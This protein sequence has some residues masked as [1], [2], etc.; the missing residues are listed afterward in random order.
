MNKIFLSLIYFS[1]VSLVVGIFTSITFSSL[2]HI[3][4]LIAYVYLFYVYFTS[5]SSSTSTLIS[6]LKTVITVLLSKS[7]LMILLMVLVIVISV[8][9]N[10]KVIAHPMGNILSAKYFLL[11]I[12]AYYAYSILFNSKFNNIFNS[13][14][15]L[16]GKKLKILLYI[17][18]IAT[19]IAAISGLIALYSG[20]N[21]IKMKQA[22]HPIRTCGLYGMYMT[23]G[24]GMQFF[25]LFL[26]GIAIYREEIEQFLKRNINTIFLWSVIIINML[27]FI[28]SFARG[29]LLGFFVA[30]PFMFF[31]KSKKI[32]A[33]LIIIPMV[34]FIFSY[35]ASDKVKG[36]FTE[37]ARVKSNETR[38]SQMY[39]AIEVFKENPW[40]GIGYKNFESQ[41]GKIKERLKLQHPEF[42]GHAHNNFFEALAS[43]GACGFLILLL[44]HIFWFIESIKRRDVVGNITW[45]IIIALFVSGQFQYTMG[46][47]ENMFFIMNLWSLSQI[48]ISKFRA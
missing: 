11:A 16:S 7:A 1:L 22:C 8:L 32:F 21:P 38:V 12:F 37:H 44:F 41:S 23:Y 14:D 10:L 5:V 29:A 4:L 40:F 26:V 28:L 33:L 19:T 47:G 2:S 27:A 15:F 31:Y 24:Y 43:T 17:F 34:L 36:L 18:F 46:D 25:C 9:T 35:V 6:D 20:F 45:P 3:L 13:N 48:Q 42:I 39:A 30:L